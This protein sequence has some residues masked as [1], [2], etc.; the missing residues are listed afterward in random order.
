[1]KIQKPFF[2]GRRGHRRVVFGHRLRDSEDDEVSPNTGDKCGLPAD[3]WPRST[4]QVAFRQNQTA[5]I[6]F[7]RH[8]TVKYEDDI[9]TTTVEFIGGL[10]TENDLSTFGLWV[11]FRSGFLYGCEG[12]QDI[13]Y[14][15][16]F[17]YHPI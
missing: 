10:G 14:V 16:C 2:Q 9:E 3:W 1:M 8:T 17:V 13:I 7:R 12:Y 11:S 5:E 15:S 4:D 6:A